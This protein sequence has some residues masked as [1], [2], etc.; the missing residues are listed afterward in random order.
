[1][2]IFQQTLTSCWTEVMRR[3]RTQMRPRPATGAFEDPETG[4]KLRF[5]KGKEGNRSAVP[6]SATVPSR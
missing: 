2:T 5:D 1:M 4:D 3:R 6:G